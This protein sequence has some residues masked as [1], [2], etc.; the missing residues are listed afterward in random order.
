M[1]QWTKITPATASIPLP[2]KRTESAPGSCSPEVGKKISL[3]LKGRKISGARKKRLSQSHKGLPVPAVTLVALQANRPAKGTQLSDKARHN[4][5]HR[6]TYTLTNPDGIEVQMSNLKEF[7]R[8]NS[9]SYRQFHNLTSGKIK[10][11]RGWQ[12]KSREWT[13]FL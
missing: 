2:P 5:K 1:Y 10:A 3:A 7:C 9:S 12:L 6:V 11:Y 8:I 13:R 4:A